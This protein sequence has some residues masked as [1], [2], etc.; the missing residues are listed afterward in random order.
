MLDLAPF[1]SLRPVADAVHATLPML[2]ASRAGSRLRVAGLRGA[3]RAF[4]LARCYRVTPQPTLCVLPSQDAAEAFAD[5]LRFFLGGAGAEGNR[6]HL[7][8]AW[9]VPSFEG[10]SPSNE[11]LAGQIE[12][13]YYL[14]STENP[15]IV[16][17]I[18]ALAQRVFPQEELIAA[19]LSV[20]TGQDIVLFD[21]V[22]H[23]VQWGY[24]RVPLVEEKGE[25]GVRGGIIDL[26]P[27]LADEPLRIEFFGDT[28]ESIRFFDPSSQRS[29]TQSDEISLL[30]VRFFS[31]RRL[32]ASRRM[33]E[34]A[35]AESEIP[36]RE[37]Q[38]IAENLKSGLPF[39]GAE[40]LLPY[41]YP[42]LE[43]IA[44]YL[45]SNTLVCMVDPVNGEAALATY[46]E[47]LA[48]YAAH[49]KTAERFASPPARLFCTEHAVAAQLE[50]HQIIALVGLENVDTD[51]AA[52]S[53]LLT[54]LKLQPHTKGGERSLAPL[55]ARITQWQ[56][57]GVQVLLVVSTS[58]QAAHLQH[59]LLGH[60]LRLSVLT[61]PRWET[62][63]T[64]PGAAIAVGHLSQ[65]FLLPAD[66]YAFV[67]EEEIFG[68]KRHR[69]RSRP[70]PVADYLTGLSQLSAGDFV[71]HVDHG[72][73]KYQGLRHLSVAGTE[74]DYLHL[75][76]TGGDRL[77]LPVE[78]INL[79]QKYTGA[80]GRAP[81]LDRLGG[82]NWEKTKRKTR[83]AIL[84]MARELLEIHAVRES[85]ERPP[86]AQLNDDYEEFVAR[87]PF[88]ETSGQRTAIEDVIAD[89]RN[90]KPMDRL[91]CGDVGYGK[92]E[93]A[94]RA[95]FLTVQNGQQVALL[96]PTTILAQQHAETF[97]RRFADYAVRVE[98]LN[99]FRS[100]QEV[101][102]TL[103]GLASG[104]V[105]IVIGTHR[106]LQRDVIFKNLGLI[107]IDEEH[108]FGVTHKEKIKKLRHLVDVLT[109]SA[110]PIPRT[111][112]M[113]LMGM[114]DLSVIETPP[115]DRQAIRT[116]VSRYDDSLVRSAILNELSRGGQVFFV[117]NRV[118][119]I[120]KMAHQLRA[121]VPEAMIVVGHGQM[122]ENELEKVMLDFLHHRANVLLCSSIIES[123]LDISTAN[124]III[125]RA[126][127]FGLAQLYQLRGRVGRSAVR[128]HAYLLIPGEHLLTE[129]ARKRLEVLQELDDLGSGFR[130]AAHDLEIRGAGNLL[131]REQ[132]GNV[133]AVGFELYAQ[134]LE[135]TV[136]ELK[137]GAIQVQIEPDIQIGLPAYIPEAY[138][139]DVNQRLVFYKKLANVT[140]RTDL[141]DLAYEM[142]DRFGPL[143][144]LV[145][146][147][148]EVMDLRRVLREYLVAGVY[149]R[150]DKVTL[151]F[152]PDAAIKGER[153]VAFVQKN[154]GRSQLSPD[155]RLTFSLKPDEDVMGAVK[156]LLQTLSEAA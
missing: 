2:R 19:I 69:R 46:S 147:F 53:A 88:E 62:E 44:D 90:D 113:A 63:T 31:A 100:A 25:V 108:R 93:V 144:E 85:T 24:R 39:P 138:I 51:L 22:D 81:A 79:V 61:E 43:S 150:A 55:A 47:R 117:H 29:T 18:E 127:Q 102:T 58:V 121:L 156:T 126:D 135:E 54:D 9:D 134:M 124:T 23:L 65:G 141:E 137:G 143:P 155:L 105:D 118:E 40:F 123:G 76:Y 115:M 4:F 28:V 49:A 16:A 96:V 139:P 60:E 32:Q 74:G 136:R 104:A 5:D 125:N 33:I 140:D 6:V 154:K 1:S 57:D 37:Q 111:L 48:A 14:L 66:R 116:Y 77:Y 95:A 68:E 30:P 114:R 83:E 50:T 129:D 59:L 12:G 149:R 78:R 64:T 13:L 26:F 27:P 153:L 56:E 45:P 106:L 71:V 35:M 70:R 94:L 80:D 110:T 92:T 89:L 21:L 152:H 8:P 151:H 145:L 103:Q 34:D 10:L 87:F 41:L 146:M 75:E 101:K 99:R 84:A 72:I 128:A 36:H 15:V 3:A 98:L 17:P 91:V 148:I 73:A 7:Y 132:H 67:T 42:T 20:K 122:P 52:S 86:V 120:E 82:Q 142:E 38:R 109:L 107:I 131:G 130:L 112:N 119:T 11:I 97:L 133:A